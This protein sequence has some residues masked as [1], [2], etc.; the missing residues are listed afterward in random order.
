[1]VCILSGMGILIDCQL[2]PSIFHGYIEW[3]S[4]AFEVLRTIIASEVVLHALVYI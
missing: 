4:H 3:Y 1:M 2:E